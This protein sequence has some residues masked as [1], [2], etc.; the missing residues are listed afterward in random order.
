MCRD[1]IMA[2]ASGHQR[3][4]PGA[5]ALDRSPY[6]APDGKHIAFTASYGGQVDRLA[7]SSVLV[8]L[9]KGWIVV[10]REVSAV[11]A[12]HVIP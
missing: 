7:R 3:D 12:A 11:T 8:S 1:L 6:F 2:P 4:C 5:L 9:P 10:L